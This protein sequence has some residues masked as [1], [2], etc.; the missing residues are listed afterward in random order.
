M[1]PQ[2]FS[3]QSFSSTVGPRVICVFFSLLSFLPS[4]LPSSLSLSPPHRPS[5]QTTNE[6]QADSASIGK[7]QKKKKQVLISLMRL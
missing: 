2:S 1:D 5:P 3:S 7:D 4:A 6:S